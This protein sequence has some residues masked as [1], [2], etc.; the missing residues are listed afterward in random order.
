MEEEK[1]SGVYAIKIS[2][3]DTAYKNQ[4]FN[5]RIRKGEIE[6]ILNNSAGVK[7]YWKW[8]AGK[9]QNVAVVN[10]GENALNLLKKLNEL[11]YIKELTLDRDGLLFGNS[12]G[13]I[14]V[15]KK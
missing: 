15:D 13:Y 11:P 5:K 1:Y 14:S 7:C 4:E 12:L 9:Y 6:S 10:N 8:A 2:L 3:T